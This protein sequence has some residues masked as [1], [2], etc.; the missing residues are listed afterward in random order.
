MMTAEQIAA[1]AESYNGVYNRTVINRL[2]RKMDESH[3]YPINGRFNA[4]DAA[5]RRLQRLQRDG[6]VIEDGLEYALALDAEISR[7][8]NEEV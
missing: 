5:I 8:V 6:L 2:F 1:K 3:L 4:T 7:I